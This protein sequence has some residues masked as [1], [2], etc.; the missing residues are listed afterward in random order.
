[1]TLATFPNIFKPLQ[2]TKAV[3]SGD[4]DAVQ[5]IRESSTALEAKRIGHTVKDPVGWNEERESVMEEII[6]HKVDQVKDFRAKLERAD[7]KT[8]FAESNV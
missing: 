6:I 7:T 4:M 3:R 8:V 1:M 5:K 2:F